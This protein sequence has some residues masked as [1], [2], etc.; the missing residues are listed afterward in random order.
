[1]EKEQEK[2]EKRRNEQHEKEQARMRSEL[3]KALEDLAAARQ[4]MLEGRGQEAELQRQMDERLAREKEKRIEH[5]Q[6]MAIRRIG[7]RE[8]YRGWSAWVTPFLEK[9]RRKRALMAA[10]SIAKCREERTARPTLWTLIC[11]V[12]ILR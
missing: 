8:L 5:T 7:K 12:L 3:G 10:S 6:Q 4:A 9:R 2:A 11:D 1:M